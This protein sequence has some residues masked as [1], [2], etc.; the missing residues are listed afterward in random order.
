MF[1]RYPVHFQQDAG[2]PLRVSVVE[3]RQAGAE[4]QQAP[5][6]ATR[7]LLRG[8][9]VVLQEVLA[10]RALL[11]V[12]LHGVIV[13]C[14]RHTPRTQQLSESILI[15]MIGGRLERGAL[16]TLQEIVQFLCVRL[17][18]FRVGF[19]EDDVQLAGTNH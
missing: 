4:A 19:A 3:V 15:Q 16:P 9:R 5:P 10:L 11:V 17:V 2:F 12:L 14:E 8:L 13:L 1:Q 7:L 18:L 6:E